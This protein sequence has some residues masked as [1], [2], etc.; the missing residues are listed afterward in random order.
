MATLQINGQFR[1]SMFPRHAAPLGAARCHRIDRHEVRLRNRAMRRMHGSHR[2]QGGPVRAFFRSAR[3][4]NGRSPRSRLSAKRRPA[5]RC[6]RP[7]SIWKSCSAAIASLARSC[8]RPRCS[9]RRRIP[10][11]PTSTPRW[12]ETS[13]A[14]A[15]MCAFAPPSRKRPTRSRLSRQNRRGMRS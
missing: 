12:Q 5:P 3:S 13:A 1:K 6:R 11:I 10:T 9:R 4:A 2:R 15:P 8:R 7:G 14:A